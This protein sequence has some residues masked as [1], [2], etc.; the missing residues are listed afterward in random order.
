MIDRDRKKAG[1]NKDRQIDTE[2]ETT[3]AVK[4]V[5]EKKTDTEKETYTDKE[6]YEY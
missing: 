6:T 5:T 1:T 3:K 2:I 4:K